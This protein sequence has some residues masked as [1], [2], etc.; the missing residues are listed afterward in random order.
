MKWRPRA[1][2]H[3]RRRRASRLPVYVGA[4]QGRL[5][6][7]GKIDFLHEAHA[8]TPM[9]MPLVT[10][11]ARGWAPKPN[12]LAAGS[13]LAG[14]GQ[15]RARFKLRFNLTIALVRHLSNAT[16]HPPF[17]T[18]PYRPNELSSDLASTVDV[19]R[20]RNSAQHGGVVAANTYKQLRGEIQGA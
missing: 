11:V 15:V 20:H 10:M 13:T 12:L 9:F 1:S 8:R 3:R 17:Q 14:L 4:R 2:Q 6:I 18:L 7:I 5:S 19:R 16:T